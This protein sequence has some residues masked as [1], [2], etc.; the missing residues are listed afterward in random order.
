MYGSGRIY[1]CT[2]C[3]RKGHLKKF[4]YA[5]LN[6]SNKHVWVR[7]DTNP[8][9]PKKIWVPKDTPNLIDTGG[10][11]S[12]KTQGE[13]VPGWWMHQRLTNISSLASL[14]QRHPFLENALGLVISPH[15]SFFF[16]YMYRIASLP[17]CYIVRCC[18]SIMLT[19]MPCSSVYYHVFMPY[20]FCPHV[21]ILLYMYFIK[22]K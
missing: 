5:K 2:H 1:I 12:S 3:G 8:K 4:C 19:C 15:K 16:I 9:G 20:N 7:Q 17:L 13:M 21:Q 14:S 18:I 10:S 22:T 6:M 11:S